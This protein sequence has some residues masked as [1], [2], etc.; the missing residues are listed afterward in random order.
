[1]KILVVSRLKSTNKISIITK[2]QMSSLE[3]LGH[4]LSYFSID[5]GGILG[6]LKALFKLR[7]K[8]KNRDFDVVHAH[9]SLCGIISSLAGAR[10]L[11]VSLMGSDVKKSVF[12]DFFVRYFVKNKWPKVVVKSDEM[13]ASFQS[14]QT[15]SNETLVLPNGVDFNLFQPIDQKEAREKLGWNLDSKIVLFGSDPSRSEKRFDLAEKALNNLIDSKSQIE[16]KCLYNIEPEDV[17]YYI[18]GSDVVLLTS[19]REGSPNIIK[20]AMACNVPIVT[21][22]VGDVKKVIGSTLGCEVVSVNQAEI[23]AN[24]LSEILSSTLIRTNGRENI[25]H[26]S[27]E[28]IA[29]SLIEFY[30]K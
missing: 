7:K 1:M 14:H 28:H 13:L 9:Y 24:A 4:E 12:N 6:Y 29:K 20:E 11:V 8:L 17:P 18:N 10:N 5:K 22:S 2:R 21:T 19:D 23:I 3:R 16:L 30:E 27:D 26:L 15:N 25:Q